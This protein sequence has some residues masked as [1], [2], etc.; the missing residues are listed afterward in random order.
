MLD[1]PDMAFNDA[2]REIVNERYILIPRR[3]GEKSTRK[4]QLGVK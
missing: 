4:I 3:N 1:T 2:V